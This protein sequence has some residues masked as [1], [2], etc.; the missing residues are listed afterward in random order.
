M[1]YHPWWSEPPGLPVLVPLQRLV[2]RSPR[3]GIRLHSDGGFDLF[4]WHSLPL[5]GQGEP[6]AG[7]K[8]HLLSVGGDQGD[9]LGGQLPFPAFT[10]GLE[11]DQVAR[12]SYVRPL[13]A[14]DQRFD[15]GDEGLGSV[16]HPSELGVLGKALYRPDDLDNANES[17][18]TLGRISRRQGDG[19]VPE[20]YQEHGSG[21]GL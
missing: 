7:R 16:L 5:G 3:P 21:V 10:L 13:D 14:A 11:L 20:S 6:L 4:P 8:A 15:V 9:H 2:G 17:P 1:R 12:G 18:V 19:N